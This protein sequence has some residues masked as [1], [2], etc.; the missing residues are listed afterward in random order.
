MFPFYQLMFNR[1]YLPCIISMKFQCMF[2]YQKR[3]LY[4]FFIGIIQ[5]CCF[6]TSYAQSYLRS[7]LTLL[8]VNKTTDSIGEFGYSRFNIGGGYALIN[9]VKVEKKLLRRLYITANVGIGKVQYNPYVSSFNTR[10]L[11]T[12]L[13][14]LHVTSKHT[15]MAMASPIWNSVGN[16]ITFGTPNVVAYGMYRKQHSKKF[17]WLLGG[18]YFTNFNTSA[19]LPLAGINYR[20]NANNDISLLLPFRFTYSHQVKKN[21]LLQ[22]GLL[23][24]GFSTP[25]PLSDTILRNRQLLV[26]IGYRNNTSTKIRWFVNMSLA[27]RGKVTL[28]ASESFTQSLPRNVLLQTGLTFVIN[29][30]HE[31]FVPE[32]D[33][34]NLN[35]LSTEELTDELLN[36]D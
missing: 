3:T 33:L 5:L 32:T 1:I 13:S 25:T 36:D 11:Q 12:G 10:L 35:N 21:Q 27:G 20:I 23:F 19:L 28:T 31:T 16:P 30:R 9:R 29:K 34:F 14:Y 2:Q 18:F 22:A 8:P 17:A 15:F 7:N 26:S 24:N 6:T 4:A